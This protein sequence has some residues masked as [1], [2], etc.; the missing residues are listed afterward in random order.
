M[1]IVINTYDPRRRYE[2]PPEVM[3]LLP[4][5][6]NDEERIAKLV[7]TGRYYTRT[8][9]ALPSDWLWRLYDA[10]Q[11][12][13]K[14]AL[15]TVERLP[16]ECQ[17]VKVNSTYF[18]EHF[19]SIYYI[20]FDCGAEY[21]GQTEKHVMQRLDE[22][23][24][25]FADDPIYPMKQQPNIRHELRT[26]IP[27]AYVLQ[28]GLLDKTT[29]DAMEQEYIGILRKPLNEKHVTLAYAPCYRRRHAYRQRRP[30]PGQRPVRRYD[31]AP[32][33]PFFGGTP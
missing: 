31:N 12:A 26:C 24:G 33:G 13:D 6:S 7:S 17:R 15:A 20:E 16:G 3:E 25:R 28:S 11:K 23:M 14:A 21:I 30:P 1:P 2:Y 29:V 5:A 18:I 27:K 22:H 19:Y 9:K 32:D 4:A 8:L 10:W